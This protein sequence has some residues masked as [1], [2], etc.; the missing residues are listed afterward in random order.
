[1]GHHSTWLRGLFT[2]ELT[3]AGPGQRARRT[4]VRQASADPFCPTRQN[5]EVPEAPARSE[6]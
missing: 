1:M 6:L 2:G 4:S 5:P 3:T